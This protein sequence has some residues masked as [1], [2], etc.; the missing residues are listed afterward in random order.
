[1]KSPVHRVPKVVPDFLKHWNGVAKKI[2][3]HRGIT[4]FLDFDGTLV[5]I[6]PRP[7]RVRL[8]A[9]VRKILVR[10]AR[11]P[12]ATLVVISGRRRPELLKH[13]GIPGIHYFGLYGW[14]SEAKSSLPA[15]VR[16]A[17]RQAAAALK[18][19]LLAYAALWIENKRSSLSVHLL[20]VPAALHARVRREIRV[21]LK[22]FRKTLHT[23]EN[24][25]DVE[26]LPRSIP[27]KGIAVSR[28]LKQAAHRKSFPLYF[29]DDFSDESGFAAVKRGASIHVGRPRPTHAQYRLRNPIEVAKALAKLEAVLSQS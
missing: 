29:G 14:E 11:N 25:R 26:I 3:A 7:E 21:R 10:L 19:L 2:R 5:A 17:L 23:V 28:L 9:A 4:V 20:H 1:M 24:I 16:A 12:L 15:D 18:P 27:G 22:P 8:R 6:A 13:I